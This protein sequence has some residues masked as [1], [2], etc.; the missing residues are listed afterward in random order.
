MDIFKILVPFLTIYPIES[1]K[2]MWKEIFVS[3]LFVMLFIMR[4]TWKQIQVSSIWDGLKIT[5]TNM[6]VN[7]TF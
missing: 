4:E 2:K 7:K 6:F 3:I 5:G 1:T